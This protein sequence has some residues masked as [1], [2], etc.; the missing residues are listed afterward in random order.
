[1]S[2]DQ[3]AID[4]S[5]SDDE[6]IDGHQLNVRFRLSCR[7]GDLETAKW[8]W[9]LGV[10]R[11][12][13]LVDLHALDEFAFR[14][15]CMNGHLETA[16]WLWSLGIGVGVGVDVSSGQ[17]QI[18][19]H[20]YYDEAFR[21]SCTRGHIATAKWLWNLGLSEDQTPIDLHAL[22][23]Y[24]FIHSCANGHIET[25]KWLWTFKDFSNEHNL[26]LNTSQ[27][28]CPICGEH[29][30]LLQFLCHESHI[31]CYRCIERLSSKR[32]VF[33]RQPFQ[34]SDLKEVHH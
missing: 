15:S 17:T 26:S 1:M 7:F 16:K 8:L 27:E 22:D 4:K 32:C 25:A 11:D 24:A 30:E 18:D 29:R 10:N 14:Y 12:Q 23:D 13:T 28:L 3:T 33:C 2:I 19:L 5:I 31:I 9:S 20:S 21:L 6:E 34:I